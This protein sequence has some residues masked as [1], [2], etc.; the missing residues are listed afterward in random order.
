V[1][2]ERLIIRSEHRDRFVV[3]SKVPLEDTRLSWKA[4]GLHA[5][6]L[7][8]PDGWVV[9]ISHLVSQSPDGKTAVVSAL[10]ELE[11]YGYISRGR[12]D[13]V[14]GKFSTSYTQVF[15]EPRKSPDETECENQ[16]RHRVRFS[17]AG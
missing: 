15:E 4:R 17:G 1:N 10:N 9:V 8:K 7:S 12:T 13:R 5:Y 3:I 14:S 2:P 11:R 6:L 16:P